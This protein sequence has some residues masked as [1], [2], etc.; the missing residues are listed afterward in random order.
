LSFTKIDDLVANAIG[1]PQVIGK[2]SGTAKAAGVPHTPWYQTGLVG[3]GAA[4][5]GGLNGA[6]FSGTVS[7]QIPIPAAVTSAY[8]KMARLSLTQT[9]NIGNIWIVDRL[10]GNVPVVTTTGAQAITSPTWP[11]RDQTAS[12]NGAKVYLALETS[13]ATGNVGAITNTTVT[14]TNSAGTGSRTATM[15]SYPATAVAGTWQLFSLQAGDDGVRSVQSVTLGTSYV[16]GAIHLVAF[17]LVAELAVPTANIA[18]RAGFTDLGLP[19]VWDNSVLQMVY[20]PTSTALGAI[21]GSCSW[22]QG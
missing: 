16:S 3:A 11:A 15:A 22:A 1:V 18:S 4:P 2:D 10:W 21:A 20:W 13:S 5:S 17:R 19:S 14:Y 6:T 7:G 9:G 8:I 12:T